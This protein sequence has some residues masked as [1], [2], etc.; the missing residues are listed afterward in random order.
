MQDYNFY[1]FS[2]LTSNS[3]IS[4]T[5][6]RMTTSYAIQTLDDASFFRCCAVAMHGMCIKTATMSMMMNVAA[7]RY[8]VAVITKQHGLFSLGTVSNTVAGSRA[9]SSNVK[10]DNMLPVS[11][12]V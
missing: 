12:S 10:E 8:T 2:T 9:M 11:Q 1:Y 6:Y 7:R 5:S 4:E 3:S